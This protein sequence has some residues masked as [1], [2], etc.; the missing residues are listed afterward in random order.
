[1]CVEKARMD[2]V[3]Q[4]CGEQ[5][6]VGLEGKKFCEVHFLE[7]W[8]QIGKLLAAFGGMHRGDIW[9]EF[10]APKVIGTGI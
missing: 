7:D 9:Q 3:C 10:L 4:E 8:N 1:M 6:T 5:A 2:G